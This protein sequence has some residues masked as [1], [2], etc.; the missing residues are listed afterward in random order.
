MASPP[1]GWY[2][3]PQ[4]SAAARLWDGTGWT[5]SLRE[6]N[7]VPRANEVRDELESPPAA[8]HHYGFVL[9]ESSLDRDPHEVDQE[10][11][12]R[13][14]VNQTARQELVGVRPRRH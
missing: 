7:E 8:S 4:G 1:A 5:G 13:F 2:P 6:V 12:E 9:E 14:G 11:M 10:W 3:D